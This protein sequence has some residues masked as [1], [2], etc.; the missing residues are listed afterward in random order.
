MAEQHLVKFDT[1]SS[2]G[3][4]SSLKH[5]DETSVKQEETS[6]C[7]MWC[8]KA[9][10]EKYQLDAHQQVRG[11]DFLGSVA[12]LKG[13][14]SRE[15]DMSVKALRCEPNGVFEG[16]CMAQ[17]NVHAMVN[18]QVDQ[19]NLKCTCHN[20][21]Y[22]D[23]ILDINNFLEIYYDVVYFLDIDFT[24]DQNFVFVVGYDRGFGY[25]L[26]YNVEEYF[27]FYVNVFEHDFA[28]QAV[29]GGSMPSTSYS[30][31]WSSSWTCWTTWSRWFLAYFVV[32]QKHSWHSWQ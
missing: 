28:L 3:V 23:D 14:T 13:R 16:A 7:A 25:I 24:Y 29:L 5:T 26:E 30:G 31:W 21:L 6:K 11:C 15:L 32:N 10:C 2:G 19:L 22:F 27:G 1:W 18:E 9:G 12:A 20:L 17:H 4:S 8:E